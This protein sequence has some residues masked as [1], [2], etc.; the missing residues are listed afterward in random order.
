MVKRPLPTYFRPSEEEPSTLLTGLISAY[1][2]DEVSGDAIDSVG[3]IDGTVTGATQHVA[4]GVV[5]YC[6]SFD[7]D[8]D[9]INF[10]HNFEY[11]EAITVA[12]W[13]KTAVKNSFVMASTANYLGWAID[14]DNSD[15]VHAGIFVS[16][17]DA[18]ITGGTTITDDVWHHI[19]I[20][21]DKQHLR[22]YID[23]ES[24]ATEVDYTTSIEYD[25]S[26]FTEVGGE[27]LL[28]FNGL[29]DLIRVWNRALLATEVLELFTAEDAGTTYPW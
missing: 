23:G 17:P 19:V 24:D 12:L 15:H 2:L 8:G 13:I 16:G 11:T 7:G 14:I 6:Y 28:W 22:L 21:Y 5:G 10:G 9:W 1:E 18:S 20:T 4:G 26:N 27:S 25:P 29:I 3:D